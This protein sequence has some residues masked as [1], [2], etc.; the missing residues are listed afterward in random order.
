[1]ALM[2]VAAEPDCELFCTDCRP[3]AANGLRSRAANLGFLKTATPQVIGPVI[4]FAGNHCGDK[5][6][7]TSGA[8][9]FQW[10]GCAEWIAGY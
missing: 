3:P 5:L 9:H 1:M 7:G 6:D 10:Q 4:A 8:R 2:L